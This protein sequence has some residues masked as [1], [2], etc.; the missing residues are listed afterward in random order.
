MFAN[1]N[2]QQKIQKAK[3]RFPRFRKLPANH[4]PGKTTPAKN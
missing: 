3:T 2:R 4:Q 1:K